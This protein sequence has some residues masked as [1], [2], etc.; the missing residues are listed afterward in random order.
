[1]GRL[2]ATSRH[3]LALQDTRRDKEAILAQFDQGEDVRTV[4]FPD[5]DAPRPFNADDVAFT[6]GSGRYVQRYL[7]AVRRNEYAVFPAEWNIA[8]QQWQPYSLADN[9]P[10]AA[11]DWTQN[12]AYCHVTA[13]NVARGKWEDEGVQCEACHGPGSIHADLAEKV[14]DTPTDDDLSGV[15]GAIVL[16]PD[17]EV[18]GQCH[19][20]GNAPDGHPYPVDYVPGQELLDEATY[21]LVSPDDSCLADGSASRRICSLTNG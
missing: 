17:P 19:R 1:M 12:C 15:R 20:Q 7:Y 4:Q 8:A 16:S 6:I 14:S 13:L 10:D 9:W 11:Y 21:T 18:C 5:E 2:H 3:A